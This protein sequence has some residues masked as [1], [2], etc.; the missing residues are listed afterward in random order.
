MATIVAIG[1]SSPPAGPCLGDQAETIDVPFRHFV[2]VSLEVEGDTELVRFEFDPTVAGATTI[3]VA[4]AQAPYLEFV[5]GAPIGVQGE[6]HTA[7][8]VGGLVGGAATDRIRADLANRSH[9]REIVQVVEPEGFGWV[10]GS[11]ADSC[12]RLRSNDEQGTVMI[13]VTGS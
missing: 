8:V 12:L 6:R 5:T 7:V 13:L 3:T 10:V 1:C 2:N 11:T 9:V 4:P